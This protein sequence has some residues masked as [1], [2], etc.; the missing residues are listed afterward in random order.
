MMINYLE[1]KI[2]SCEEL[3]G[4]EKEIWAFKQCL[5]E[6]RN[7]GNNTPRISNLNQPGEISYFSRYKD[8]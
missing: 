6:I 8:E 7:Y 2:R 5:K 4:M 1:K 3:G